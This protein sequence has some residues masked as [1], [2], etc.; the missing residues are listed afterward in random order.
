[1]N[2]L[3][4]DMTRQNEY[5]KQFQDLY[6]ALRETEN[7]LYSDE[8]LARLPEVDPKHMYYDEWLIRKSSFERFRKY[9]EHK[10]CDLN[11]L[12]VGCGNGWLSHALSGIRRSQVTGIDINS[13]E[14]EQARRVF[15]GKANLSFILGDLRSAG[16]TPLSIDIIVF[17]ASIQYFENLDE[18]LTA[19]FKLLKHYGEVHIIDTKFYKPAEVIKAKERSAVYFHSL[20]FEEMSYSY[21][22]HSMNKLDG[23]N[24][25]VMYDPN[26]LFNLILKRKDPFHWIMIKK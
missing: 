22:H 16:L 15:F 14:L 20:G 25:Q 12:E 1:L 18:I 6:I 9:L 23:Y 3:T 11:I 4:N 19:A 5:E 21:F 10:K 7:R 2:T 13:I 17:A 8:E 24:Y 26:H